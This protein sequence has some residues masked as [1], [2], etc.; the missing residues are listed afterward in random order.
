MTARKN[1]GTNLNKPIQLN[2]FLTAQKLAK[3]ERLSEK[4]S[5]T[6]PANHDVISIRSIEHRTVYKNGAFCLSV[7]ISANR[8]KISPEDFSELRE[9]FDVQKT[10]RNR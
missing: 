7:S 1:D 2:G 6:N 3:L 10:G 9:I 8:R 5:A 4:K